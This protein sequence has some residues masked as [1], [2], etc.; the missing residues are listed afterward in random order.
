MIHDELG[1]CWVHGEDGHVAVD[2][3]SPL[4][5]LLNAEADLS[6]DQDGR[7]AVRL[8]AVRSLHGYLFEQGAHPRYVARRL[9]LATLRFN[10]TAVQSLAKDELVA[11]TSDDFDTQQRALVRALLGNPRAGEK[12][13]ESHAAYM[14][15]VLATAWRRLASAAL[16]PAAGASIEALMQSG[17]LLADE[18]LEVRR[19]TV[20]EWLRPI[21]R[22]GSLVEA[23]KAV[24]ALTRG[25]WPELVYN[26]TGEEI[27]AL[28][29]QT[30]AAVSEREH[31]LINRPIERHAG[32]HVTLRHQK[33]TGACA[34]YAAAQIGN[35]HRAD[36]VRTA[37]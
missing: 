36:S 27:A 25:F 4:G 2:M 17:P 1:R 34:R 7:M 13:V 18:E 37:A 5:A 23:L 9:V 32:R 33:S 26:M 20:C 29:R 19:E 10:A 16:P 6:E 21:W 24:Y 30:R 11:V 28:F 12:Q 15:S 31:R 14:Q 22:G 8:E 3:R 35:T